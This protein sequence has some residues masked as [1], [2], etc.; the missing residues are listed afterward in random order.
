META[1]AQLKSSMS[2]ISGLT[3]SLSSSVGDDGSG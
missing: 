1:L 3:A 2:A